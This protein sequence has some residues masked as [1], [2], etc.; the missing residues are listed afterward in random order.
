[1]LLG[2]VFKDGVLID[3]GVWT[4]GKH[5]NENYPEQRIDISHDTNEWDDVSYSHG[6]GITFKEYQ[7]NGNGWEEVYCSVERVNRIVEYPFP[8]WFVNGSGS[9][10]NITFKVSMDGDIEETNR[11]YL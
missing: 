5:W 3:Q 11:G 10:P 1:M 6:D 9:I 7:D 4:G 8:A 2:K